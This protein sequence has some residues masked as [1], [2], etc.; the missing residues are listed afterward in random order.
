LCF[1]LYFATA[2][3]LLTTSSVHDCVLIDV[4]SAIADWLHGTQANDGIALVANCPQRMVGRYRPTAR[5]TGR[6]WLPGTLPAW[7]SL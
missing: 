2:R 6:I 1:Y 7:L 5:T 4:T 3:V